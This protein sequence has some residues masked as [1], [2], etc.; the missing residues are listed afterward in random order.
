MSKTA[1]EWTEE[2]D[3]WDDKGN[4][5]EAIKCFDQA[6]SID[7][8]YGK[9]W[10]L[11]AYSYDKLK[12]PAE[13]TVE[14]YRKALA[15]GYNEEQTYYNLAVELFKLNKNVEAIEAYEKCLEKNP[16]K[17]NAWENLADVYMVLERNEEAI[18]TW[19]KALELEPSRD[20]IHP[21][22]GLL[23]EDVGRE[24][25]AMERYN[26][27]L[28]LNPKNKH[29]ILFKGNLLSK[30]GKYKE[31]LEVYES[32]ESNPPECAKS[33]R[34]G[35]AYMALGNKEKAM[36]MYGN[37]DRMNPSNAMG[38]CYRGQCYYLLSRKEEALKDLKK[39]KEFLEQKTSYTPSQIKIMKQ[40]LNSI[41]ETEEAEQRAEIA[42]KQMN[43]ND[44]IT[45][46]FIQN[47]KKLQGEKEKVQQQLFSTMDRKQTSQDAENLFEMDRIKQEFEKQL[48]QIRAEM[49]QVKSEVR[50]V[51]VKVE[52]LANNMEE[53]KKEIANKMDDFDKKLTA[54]LNKQDVPLDD[55]KKLKGYFVAFVGTFSSTHVT[56]QV[57]DSGQG[58]IDSDNT[59]AT[60]LSVIASFAPF[61]GSVLKSGIKSLGDFLQSK[62]MKTNAR[63]MKNLAP[64][65]TK[66]SQI[67]GKAAF[68]ILMDKNKQKALIEVTDKDLREKSG[69]IFAKISNFCA[70][71][72]ESIDATLYSSLYKTAAER[73]GHNDA[74]DLIEKW[75]A[76]AIT[77]Y[78]PEEQFVEETLNKGKPKTVVDATQTPSS[79]SKE[80]PNPQSS[81]CNIF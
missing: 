48:V 50:E 24:D 65:A 57:I 78:G 18:A 12:K 3:Q 42:L 9:A 72:N 51:S 34:M 55:Q 13:E 73:V 2:G 14:L 8:N 35:N 67:I 20:R 27:C 17:T 36:Q 68:D 69:S 19:Y 23:L 56:S 62:E 6:L 16:K 10:F 30:Q 4:R 37:V 80:Q 64:D 15:T 70:Q 21:F 31:A 71:L 59:T 60:I 52:K 33:Y 43:K 28:R 47:V 54:E 1:A 39:A 58:Q 25:E 53:M 66:L 81:C 77:P 41:F 46:K 32:I 76:G 22:Q 49:H 61:V 79:P 75:L 5:E 7:P 26:V 74:N 63:K 44:T 11:K 45:Q 38:Y 40:T 29:A